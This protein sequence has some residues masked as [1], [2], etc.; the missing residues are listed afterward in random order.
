MVF[1][2]IEPNILTSRFQDSYQKKLYYDIL[3][4]QMAIL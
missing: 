1:T 2:K 4:T 3:L